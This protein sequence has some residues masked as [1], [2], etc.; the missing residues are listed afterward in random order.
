MALRVGQRQGGPPTWGAARTA[1]RETAGLAAREGKPEP[2]G[3][4]AVGGPCPGIPGAYEG[5]AHFQQRSREPWG[6]ILSFWGQSSLVKARR[7]L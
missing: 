7:K 4:V 2:R 5:P 6:W 3:E 1:R